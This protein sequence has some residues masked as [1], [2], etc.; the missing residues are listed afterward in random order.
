MDF[1]FEN[2]NL[3]DIADTSKTPTNDVGEGEKN[4][5]YAKRMEIF[6]TKNSNATGLSKCTGTDYNVWFLF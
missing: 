4:V 6:M 3:V 5:D 2:W 1:F